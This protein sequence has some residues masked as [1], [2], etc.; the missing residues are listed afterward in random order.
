MSYTQLKLKPEYREKLKALAE[1]ENRSMANMLEALIDDL[2]IDGLAYQ[3]SSYGR[4]YKDGS[5]QATLRVRRGSGHE[6]AH[7]DFSHTAETFPQSPN[8]PIVLSADHRLY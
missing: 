6:Q 2:V 8:K 3:L 5:R 1:A 4:P 7:G